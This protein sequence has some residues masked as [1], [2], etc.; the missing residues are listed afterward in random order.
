MAQVRQSVTALAGDDRLWELVSN[1]GAFVTTGGSIR[2]PVTECFKVGERYFIEWIYFTHPGDIYVT[3]R[4]HRDTSLLVEAIPVGTTFVCYN[5]DYDPSLDPFDAAF[6]VHWRTDGNLLRKIT[7]QDGDRV[8]SGH[9]I[10]KRAGSWWFKTLDG[11]TYEVGQSHKGIRLLNER[12]KPEG[13]IIH[14]DFR[15]AA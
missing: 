11:E 4:V 12:H 5:Q 7:V 8:V 2:K 15:G 6:D 14:V 1:G 13:K 10:D 9:I 3:E